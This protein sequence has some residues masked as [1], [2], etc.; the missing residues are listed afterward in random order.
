MWLKKFSF[1]PVLHE[2]VGGFL[3]D[4]SSIYKL[5]KNGKKVGEDT[6]IHTLETKP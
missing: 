3:N 1:N 6:I 4:N 2:R 5:I